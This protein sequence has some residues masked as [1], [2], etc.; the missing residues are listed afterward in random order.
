[1]NE[2]KKKRLILKRNI[3]RAVN[4][5]RKEKLLFITLVLC[6]ASLFLNPKPREWFGFVNYKPLILLYC[7]M[8]VLAGIRRSSAFQVA[9]EFLVSRAKT[10]RAFT[11]LMVFTAFFLSMLITNTIALLILLPL[12]VLALNNT[13]RTKYAVPLIT[14][15]TI[16]A[17][18]GSA[19]TPFGN[20]QNLFLYTFYGMGFMEFLRIQLPFVLF[21]AGLLLAASLLFKNEK[22]DKRIP[23]GTSLAN[24]RYMAVYAGLFAVT[25]LSVLD[26]VNY[27]AV[28]LIVLFVAL[29]VDRAIVF[30]ADFSLI[31]TLAAFFVI[32]GN[33]ASVTKISGL[34]E[35]LLGF[36]DFMTSVVSSQIIGNFPAAVF[37]AKFTDHAAPI[38]LGVSVGGLGVVNAS[39]ANIISYRIFTQSYISPKHRFFIFFILIGLLFLLLNVAFVKLFLLK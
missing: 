3:N 18:A 8:I 19:L 37:L 4:A 28:L 9:A 31:V 16:A 25:L 6:V 7:L 26:I 39:F 20:F 22:F 5:V 2:K 32:A 12:T 17:N 36:S 24:A 13:D 1:M 34:M 33:I 38:L 21:N 35:N 30:K 10:V 29:I 15:E 14:L 27:L 23:R 11:L